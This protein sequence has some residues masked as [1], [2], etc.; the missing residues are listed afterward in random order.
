[1]ENHIHAAGFV[2]AQTWDVTPLCNLC[3]ALTHPNRIFYTNGIWLLESTFSSLDNVLLASQG[4][5]QGNKGSIAFWLALNTY[6]VVML[7]WLGYVTCIICCNHCH[8][9]IEAVTFVDV[10]TIG[11]DGKQIP[12]RWQYCWCPPFGNPPNQVLRSCF[13]TAGNHLSRIKIVGGKP[14]LNYHSLMLS[15][16]GS[17]PHTTA[18]NDGFTP[19]WAAW[20]QCIPSSQHYTRNRISSC[21]SLVIDQPP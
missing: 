2:C 3:C 9:G 11:G 5:G 13:P 7:H 8:L 1:M 20:H 21:S 4:L 6:L 10:T 12:V 14:H 17:S 15:A 16:L 18:G 19:Q